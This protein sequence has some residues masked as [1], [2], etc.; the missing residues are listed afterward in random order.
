MFNTKTTTERP[1]SAS[2]SGLVSEST[3]SVPTSAR[4]KAKRKSGSIIN[5][6]LKSKKDKDKQQGSPAIFKKE[7]S[8]SE[9]GMAAVEF[10]PA[11]YVLYFY[12]IFFFSRLFIYIFVLFFVTCCLLLSYLLYLFLFL[13]AIFFLAMYQRRNWRMTLKRYVSNKTQNRREMLKER[14]EETRKTN[15]SLTVFSFFSC[16]LCWVN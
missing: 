3:G 16:G 4:K 11:G 15:I 7:D 1:L 14:I 13:I 5:M 12:F 9:D 2:M 10:R 6:T 8:G